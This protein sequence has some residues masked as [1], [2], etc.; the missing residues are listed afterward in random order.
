M[1]RLR[2]L[3]PVLLLG[4]GS[5]TKRRAYIAFCIAHVAA[6]NFS[7]F[8]FGT[9]VAIFTLT[10]EFKNSPFKINILMSVGFLSLRGPFM[11]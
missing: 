1:Q 9:A 7:T 2:S 6:N 4:A 3:S 8:L 11:I 5:S 10:G